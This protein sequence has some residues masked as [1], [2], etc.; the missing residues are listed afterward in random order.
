MA[1]QLK[2]QE[3]EF[4]SRAHFEVALACAFLYE[5]SGYSSNNTMNYDETTCDGFCLRDELMTSFGLD[6]D[7]VSYTLEKELD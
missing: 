2:K 1:I 6:D 7:D 5:N 3:K 4:K